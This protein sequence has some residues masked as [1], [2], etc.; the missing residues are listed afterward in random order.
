MAGLTP[1]PSQ[2]GQSRRAL[3]SATAGQRHIRALAIESAW[4]WRRFQPTSALAQWD[5]RRCGAGSARRRQL[6]MVALARQLLIALW[7]FL[8]IGVLPEGA[9][10]KAEAPR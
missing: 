3:G 7:R 5:E 1:M 6:G 9:V 8:K 4:A 2:S 10:L